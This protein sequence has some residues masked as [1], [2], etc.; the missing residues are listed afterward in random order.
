MFKYIISGCSAIILTACGGGSSSSGDFLETGIF[1]D[2]PVNGL[3]YK[4][5]TQSGYT[6][7]KGNFLY[8]NGESITF[9]LG[10]LALG[11]AIARSMMTPLTLTNDNDINNISIKARNILRLLQTLDSNASDHSQIILDERLRDLNISDLNLESEADLTTLLSRAEAKTAKNYVL[12]DAQSAEDDFIKYYNY[13]VSTTTTTTVTDSAL[14][15][16]ACQ[17]CHGQNFEK[18][19]LNKSKIVANM[20]KDNV[21]KALLGY[22]YGTYGGDMAGV[23]KGQV[24]RYSDTELRNSGLGK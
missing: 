22:K 4:T 9:Y 12:K 23:M 21:T 19:A 3:Y 24:S 13:V 7:S 16:S 8:K 11:Q 5:Q 15:L 20:S 2:S 17:A 1:V 6:D 18:S 14:N 10:N